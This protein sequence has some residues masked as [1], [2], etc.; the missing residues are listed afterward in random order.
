M[1]ATNN[2]DLYV[3]AYTEKDIDSFEPLVQQK[4]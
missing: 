2:L 1:I 3:S 4:H